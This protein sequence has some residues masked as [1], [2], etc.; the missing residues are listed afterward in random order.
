MD[1]NTTLDT[2][3]EAGTLGLVSGLVN[4]V[5]ELAGAHMS[6][7]RLEVRDELRSLVTAFKSA[8][9]AAVGI[10][11]AVSLICVALALLLYEETELAG[12]ASFGIVGLASA[13]LAVVL[14]IRAAVAARDADGVPDRELKRAAHD[15]RWMAKRARAAAS[16]DPAQIQH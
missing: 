12:W 10:G 6:A 7:A 3:R 2:D 5:R 14:G 1:D 9:F 16:D 4:D 8:A 13:A 15:V 11:V